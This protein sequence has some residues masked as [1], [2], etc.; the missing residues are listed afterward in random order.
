M[1]MLDDLAGLLLNRLLWTS[2]QA[3]LLVGFVALI[4]RWVPRLPATVRS[5]LWWLIA[6]QVVIGLCWQAPV[7]LPLLASR[8]ATFTEHL[9]G[10][11]APQGH[12]VKPSGAAPQPAKI[13]GW[14]AFLTW[15][16]G[17][18]TLWLLGLLAQ[19]PAMARDRRRMRVWLQE[20]DAPDD[21][22][23]RRS[24]ELSRK[25]GLR[26]RPRLRV[27]SAITSPLVAGWVRPVILW[28]ARSAFTREETSL[29]LA[30][31]LAHLKRG[32]LWLACIPAIAQCLFFFHPF[33]R[34]S[35]REYAMHR[36]AAC[37]A[38]AMRVCGANTS[39][40]GRLLLRLGVS[41]L[42]ATVLAGA[43]ATFRGLKRRL[44]MLPLAA[45]PAPRVRGWLLVALIAAVGVLPYR[46]VAAS[47]PTIIHVKAGV[48]PDGNAASSPGHCNGV[49]ATTFAS[50][51]PISWYTR[52]L[53]RK[54]KARFCSTRAR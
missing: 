40:Y 18:A 30:H 19:M 35:A 23:R 43:S 42:R 37:D 45:A 22:L 39:D 15:R 31:E 26:R 49:G 29:A 16:N 14:K 50:A 54:D 28:P 11:A 27:S 1:S 4:V 21:C 5:A 51:A 8:V 53:R 48:G 17:L 24:E 36:E 12:L 9:Q 3:V 7:R 47:P 13:V 38:L 6:L 34:A 41:G 10:P 33:V 46:V 52:V 2:L 44:L 20:S 25:L 32:D